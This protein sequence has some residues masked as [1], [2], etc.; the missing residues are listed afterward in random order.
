M[1]ACEPTNEAD[2]EEYC[3]RWV[4]PLDVSAISPLEAEDFS[5]AAPAARNSLHLGLTV[6][7]RLLGLQPALPGR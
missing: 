5:A 2:A 3:R 4:R 1:F 7:H 6:C